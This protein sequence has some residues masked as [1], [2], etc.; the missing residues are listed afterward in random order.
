MRLTWYFLKTIH[1]KNVRIIRKIE[2]LHFLTYRI[3]AAM[4]K[5]Q[6]QFFQ[7]FAMK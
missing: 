7:C 6:E 4:N 5:F 1:W 2:F 3:S